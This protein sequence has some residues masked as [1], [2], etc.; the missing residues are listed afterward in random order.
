MNLRILL[1]SLALLTACAFQIDV[2]RPLWATAKV[3]RTEY[4][5]VNL[6]VSLRQR[7]WKDANKVGSCAYASLISA[8]RW[9]CQD[10]KAAAIRRDHSG[11]AHMGTGDN[12]LTLME[13]LDDEQIAYDFTSQTSTAF[14]EL[15][16]TTRRG[17]AVT[18]MGGKHMV[19]LVHLDSD[20]AGILDS[21]GVDGIAWFPREK[22][23]SEWKYSGG[24]AVALIYDPAPP[25][26]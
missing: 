5:T 23:L 21:N 20:V 15:A 14:L 6:P 12:H 3:I 18:V 11:A 9:G 4:P 26:P 22:F 17:A 13:E 25:L 2:D 8:L 7:N 10:D 19:L 24:W 1:C 16:L